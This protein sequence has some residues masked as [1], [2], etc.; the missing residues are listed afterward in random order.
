[1]R[2]RKTMAVVALGSLVVPLGVTALS[3]PAGAVSEPEVV[4]EGLDN[5]YKISFGPDGSLYVAE[6]GTGGDSTACVTSP[7]DESLELCLGATGAVTRVDLDAGS[8]ERV[9]DDLPSLAPEGGNGAVGPVDVEVGD[10]GQLFVT[11]GLG[12]SLEDRDGLGAGAEALGTVVQVDPTD[13]TWEVFADLLAFEVANDPDADQPESEGIDS[14]PFDLEP[15]ADGWLAVDAGGNDVLSIADDGTVELVTVLPWGEAEAPPFL[16]APP[17]TMLPVQPVPTAVSVGADRTLVSQLTGFPFPVGGASIFELADSELTAVEEGFTNVTDVTQ[18]EAGNV[19][20]LEYASNGL[21][22]GE[23]VSRVTQVRT[24][25]TRKVLLQDELQEANGIAIGPDGRLY[26][27]S[28]SQSAGEGEVIAVDLTVPADPATAPAC[29]PVDV[30]GAGFADVGA[31][32]HRESI[33]CVAWWGI[34]RGLADGTF[35]GSANAVRGQVISIVARILEGAVVE[36]PADPPDAFGDDDGNVHEGNINALADLGIVTGVTADEVEPNDP[37]TRGEL[38]S[39]LARAYEEIT[40]AP[41]PAG[42]DAFGDD[43][44]STHED[45]INAVAAAGWVVGTGEGTFAP[46]A[47]TSRAQLASIAARMLGTLVDEGVAE[48]PDAA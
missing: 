7:E 41:L 44:G 27:S 6:A 48:P 3:S 20:V 43:D 35:G 45:A 46:D 10:G 9:V 13:G 34:V 12:G 17:G 29:N 16:G 39:L 8:Q 33:D 5:P 36:L 14:N 19:Y 42:D 2:G 11:I 47:P 28:G 37:V 21:L 26:V 18:D 15:A 22:S 23:P 25:G 24:D 31:S 4:A 30:P 32:V 38:A 1:M 40:G